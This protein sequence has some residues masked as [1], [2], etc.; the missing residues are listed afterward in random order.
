M[1]YYSLKVLRMLFIMCTFAAA[2]V[3]I[4]LARMLSMH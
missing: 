3:C 4:A 1:L 2:K